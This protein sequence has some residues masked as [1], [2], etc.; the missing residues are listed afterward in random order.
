MV[1]SIEKIGLINPLLVA[2]RD[3]GLILVS[4]W[5]RAIS[6]QKLSLSPIPVFRI[7]ENDDLSVFKIAFFENLATRSFSILEKAEIVHKLK[8]FGEKEKDIIKS[9]LPL[10]DIPS[11]WFYFKTYLAFSRFEA[12]LK[13]AVHEKKMPF[14]T[15]KFLAEFSQ[16]ERK[17]VLPLIMPLGQNK[18]KEILAD[19]FEL[20]RKESVTVDEILR[21]R[22]IRKAC[23]AENLSPLQQSDQ[24]RVILKRKR[25]PSLFNQ[26]ELVNS[27]MKRMSWPRDIE[28][29][30]SPFFEDED[31]LLSFSFKNKQDYIQRVTKLKELAAKREFSELFESP[32]DE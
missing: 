24:V 19:L 30:P 23:E 25:N 31:F 12:K 4:G 3:G 15:L 5:K 11:T 14:L 16:E 17:L 8:E 1:L 9:F 28:I 13:E 22:E 10:L 18:Q 26:K 6:C 29:H 20:S 21:S 32:S 27:A 2:L 7:E